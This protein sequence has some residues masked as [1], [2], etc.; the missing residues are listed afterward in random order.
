MLVV[1]ETD[2]A[3]EVRR[4]CTTQ[5]DTH[6]FFSDCRRSNIGMPQVGRWLEDEMKP[7]MRRV[8]D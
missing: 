6:R 5:P 7:M 8:D 4:F 1:I 3:V 2:G